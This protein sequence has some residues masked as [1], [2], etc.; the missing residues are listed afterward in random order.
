M[1]LRM[2]SP[3][4]S[5]SLVALFVALG[6]TSYA[7]IA[8]PRNSVGTVQL[9]NGGVASVDLKASAV[10]A[11]KLAPNAVTSAKLTEGAV[12]SSDIADGTLAG[13]DVAANTLGG[14]QIDESTLGIVPSAT[15]ATTAT[16]VESERAFAKRVAVS[17]TNNDVDAARAAATEVPI[18]TNGSLTVYG[19]CYA[20]TDD[21]QVFSAIHVRST[22]GGGFLISQGSG[23]LYGQGADRVL[24]PTTA[25][26]DR[27]FVSNNASVDSARAFYDFGAAI[28]GDGSAVHYQVVVASKNGTIPNATGWGAIGDGCLLSG[29]FNLASGA[30]G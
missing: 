23:W 27:Y 29:R 11:A 12:T 25:E 21:D 28:A 6:G 30:L 18:L 3:A 13:A 15:S 7:A 9:K 14:G 2:P 20:D 26:A 1:R 19:K 24:A 22:V 4:T 8:L 10:S 16:S 17:A 5:I